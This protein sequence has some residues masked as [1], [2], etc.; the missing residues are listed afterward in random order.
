MA[1]PSGKAVDIRSV[2]SYRQRKDA[3]HHKSAAQHHPYSMLRQAPSLL[4]FALCHQVNHP[5]IQR[6]NQKGRQ[7]PLDL[8]SLL[9]KPLFLF[10]GLSVIQPNIGGILRHIIRFQAGYFCN[11]NIF[12]ICQGKLCQYAVLIIRREPIQLD[13]LPFPCQFLFKVGSF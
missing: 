3:Q 10:I 4:F 2:P 12:R 6:G 9:F 1:G 8:L 5:A 13:I 7:A 11:L